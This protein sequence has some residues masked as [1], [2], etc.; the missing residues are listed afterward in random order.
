MK[1]QPGID[2]VSKEHLYVKVVGAIIEHIRQG[3]MKVGD[4]LPSERQLAAMLST[5]RNTVREAIRVLQDEGILRVE[6][7]SGAYIQREPPEDDAMRLKLMKVNYRDLLDIKMWLEQL[8]IRRAVA[9]ATEKQVAVLLERANAL[10]ALHAE[11]RYSIE[12]DRAFHIQLFICAGS[13]TL[14][15][16]VLSLIDALNRYSKMLDADDAW[17]LTVPYH[18][19]IAEGLAT[20]NLEFAL[21]AHEYIHQYDMRALDTL[22]VRSVEDIDA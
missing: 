12:V 4:K 21:A 18:V 20:K 13:S 6:S 10:M 14:S 19:D 3:E 2:P 5:G 9:C 17:L 1:K 7:G 22:G 15:Q 16:L 11:G 8:A